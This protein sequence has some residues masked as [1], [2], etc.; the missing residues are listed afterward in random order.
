MNINKYFIDILRMIGEL[1]ET[2]TATMDFLN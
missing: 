1:A 2:V